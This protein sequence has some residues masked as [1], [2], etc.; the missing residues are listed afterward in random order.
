MKRIQNLAHAK[1]QDHFVSSIS[2]HLS[3]IDWATWLLTLMSL[4]VLIC[5]VKAAVEF[6]FGIL[7]SLYLS[8]IDIKNTEKRS[9]L[10]IS[11]ILWNRLHN[12]MFSIGDDYL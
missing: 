1:A 3:S 5:A 4:V 6:L 12:M 11:K 8:A 10:K 7:K 2:T 9:V